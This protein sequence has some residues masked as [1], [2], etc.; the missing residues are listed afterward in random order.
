M[1]SRPAA[2]EHMIAIDR[3][4]KRAAGPLLTVAM[5]ERFSKF[6]LF[7][8]DEEM[9]ISTTP[10][11]GRRFSANLQKKSHLSHAGSLQINNRIRWE[12]AYE[13]FKLCVKHLCN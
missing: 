11:P 8:R 6:L 13:I 12:R 9:T 1:Y 7:T 4:G 5:S 10:P 2:P 3:N